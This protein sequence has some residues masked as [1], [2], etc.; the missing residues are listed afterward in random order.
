MRT[1][2]LAVRGLPFCGRS[3]AELEKRSVFDAHQAKTLGGG[4]GTGQ[5]AVSSL[6]DSNHIISLQF[7]SSDLHQGSGEVAHHMVEEPAASN[8]V[9]KHLSLRTPEDS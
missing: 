3:T 8:L 6:Q 4:R 9:D 7:T 5:R 2:A 1:A